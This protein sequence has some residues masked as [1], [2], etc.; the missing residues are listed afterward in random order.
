MSNDYP[1]GSTAKWLEMVAPV[2]GNADGVDIVCSVWKHAAVCCDRQYTGKASR[3]LL[4]KW[5]KL[6]L[7]RMV[8]QHKLHK[9][10]AIVGAGNLESDNAIVHPMSTALQSRMMHLTLQLDTKEWLEWANEA[11]LNFRVTSYIEFKPQALYTFRPDHVDHTYSSPRTLEFASRVIDVC[12]LGD[13][14][15]L[16]MLAGCIGEGTAADLVSFMR[17]EDDLP[18]FKDIVA[19]PTGTRVPVEPGTQYLLCGSI[20]AHTD[21]DSIDQVAKYVGRLPAEFQVV[22]LRGIVKRNNNLMGHPA[23]Q[24]WVAGAAAKLFA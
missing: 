12:P 9:N 18:K 23:I 7:D 24:K 5:Y 14:D 4:N 15:L 1:S 6:I 19:D 13:P 16:P 2:T 20:G 8:G 3:T 17:L 10:V 11:N 21:K 22:A